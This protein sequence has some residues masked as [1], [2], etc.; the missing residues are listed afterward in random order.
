MQK[1]YKTLQLKGDSIT[2]YHEKILNQDKVHKIIE[3][4]KKKKTLNVALLWPNLVWAPILYTT[5]H[6]VWERPWYDLDVNQFRS[7]N[8]PLTFETV[9]SVYWVTTLP[10]TPSPSL[11]PPPLKSANCPIPPILVFS[12]PPLHS[13]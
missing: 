11:S 13:P 4:N 8:Q 9:Y 7:Y 2:T 10:K 6:F 1:Q 5:S 3:N 12:E